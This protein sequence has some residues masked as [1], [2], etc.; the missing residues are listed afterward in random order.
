VIIKKEKIEEF[1]KASQKVFKIC[2]VKV[3][4]GIAFYA[5]SPE[6]R[7]PWIYTRDL[8]L[9]SSG[10]LELGD[11]KTAKACCQF[12]LS[13]QTEH[14][15]WFQRYNKEGE[16]RDVRV[17]EDNTPLAG[18]SI[19]KYIKKSKD[20][21]F[22]DFAE[23]KLKKAAF[24]IERQNKENLKRF[25]LVHST[26]S[27]HEGFDAYTLEPLNQG[28]EIW[29]NSVTSKFFEMMGEIYQNKHYQKL[30]NTIKTGI[31][32][33]LIK[34]GRFIRR[35]TDEKK[36]DF[37]PCV[38]LMFPEYFNLFK[39]D[40]FLT[41]EQSFGEINQ[42]TIK[43]IYQVLWDEEL[44]GIRARPGYD[45]KERHPGY[46]GIVE[47]I[48]PGPWIIYT[49]ILAQIHFKLNEKKQG[50]KLIKWILN[51]S[52]QGML[53]QH[54]VSSKNFIKYKEKEKEYN[55]KTK[56]GKYLETSMKNLENLEEQAK[57]SKKLFYSLP[58][59][60]SHIETLKVLKMANLIKE[61]KLNF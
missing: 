12:F 3:E 59:C 25:N 22:T 52:K 9:I 53:S 47:A 30:A 1:L 26:T 13:C 21:N 54:I 23:D 31:K 58:L 36:T 8:S 7:Y 18:L 57:K 37:S 2:Q 32:K 20:F 50:I 27:I 5:S 29:N 51:N 44:E 28:Y 39:K 33:Y 19:L 16:R 4:K 34:K 56:T 46:Q 49:A 41:K 60:W 35:I 11:L 10:F 24:L 55:L 61:F 48:V 38:M 42:N 15:E 45:W 6:T 14:G 40:E 43:F 17:Q